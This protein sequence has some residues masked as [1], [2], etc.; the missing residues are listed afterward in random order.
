M[1]AFLGIACFFTALIGS[2]AWAFY[3]SGDGRDSAVVCTY[4]HDH[5]GNSS[6]PNFPRLAGQKAGYLEKQLHAFQD[7]T[8]GDARA[9]GYMWGMMQNRD[10]E[11]IHALALYFSSQKPA[12]NKKGNAAWAAR[13]KAIFEVGVTE[14]S[15][16]ACAACHGA[17]GEGT[18]IA[19]RLAG[20]HK[21]YIMTQLEAFH[22]K[23]RKEATVMPGIASLLTVEDA[24]AV[25]NY[26]QGL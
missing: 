8:R 4:C 20:Q 14:R 26:L 24:K 16:P 9:V 19:P 12:P 21:N 17:N 23:D 2:S 18:D 22:D 10:D 1:K 13:G 7:H 15:I 25:A 11:D 5:N 6:N 3:G